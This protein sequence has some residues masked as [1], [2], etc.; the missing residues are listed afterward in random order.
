MPI[1]PRPL[2]EP[3]PDAFTCADALRLGAS[4]RRLRAGD[5]ASPFHGVRV[6]AASGDEA[7]GRAASGAV[8][9][10]GTASPLERDRRAHARI[11]DRVAEH[12]PV[13]PVDAFYAGM[14]AAALWEL[15]L[16]F[17]FDPESPLCVAVHAPDR[18][19]RRAGI[20]GRKLSPALATTTSTHGVRV[21]DPASTW[22]MLAGEVGIDG[23]VRLGDALVRVPRD[24]R[25]RPVPAARLADL[26][27][28]R[29][30][31]LVPRRRARPLLL[32]ALEEIRIGSMSPLET[33]FRLAAGRAG[34]PEPELD[35][36]IRDA[37]GRLCGIA[38]AVYRRWRVVVEVEGRQHRSSDA[39]WN[40][41]LAKYAAFAAGGWEVVRVTGDGIRRREATAEGIAR[42]AAA[43][44][45]HG[46]PT[47]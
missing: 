25:G 24:D 35:V 12:A 40:R 5:L 13:M 2:P 38:D 9:P 36:E 7:P 41:D 21:T 27:Q 22:A 45:R 42:V 47:R 1:L 11:R 3:L 44:R 33:D 29:T 28:L 4:A 39:Q 43:L 46:W 26:D 20:V 10:R 30:A 14:T 17:R 19:R 8:A 31:A 15:P 6:R 32:A 18:G 37:R 16:P 34:L 23:L